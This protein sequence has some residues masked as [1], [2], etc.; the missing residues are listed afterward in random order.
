[1]RQLLKQ[2]TQHET[3]RKSR[4]AAKQKVLIEEPTFFCSAPSA[5]LIVLIAFCV[6]KYHHHHHLTV[7]HNMNRQADIHRWKEGRKKRHISSSNLTGSGIEMEPDPGD[8]QTK[9]AKQT[10]KEYLS[11]TLFHKHAF[12]KKNYL[13]S[14]DLDFVCSKSKTLFSLKSQVQF[15]SEF[16]SHTTHFSQRHNQ[17]KRR[18]HS[19]SMDLKMFSVKFA[20]KNPENSRLHSHSLA[21]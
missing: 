20:S 15:L 19:C 1:M 17:S 8:Q 7:T 16:H 18:R 4:Q 14:I 6:T 11:N 9:N 21:H 2:K 10:K 12:I 5:L 13:P 3:E